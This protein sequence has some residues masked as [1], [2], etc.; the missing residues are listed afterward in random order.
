MDAQA[1]LDRIAVSQPIKPDFEALAQL[2]LAH[3]LTV[4]FE[5]LS[6]M[7]GEPILLDEARLLEKIVGRRRGGFCYELNGAFAWLLRQVGFD[8]TYISG[9]VYNT[10]TG[11]FGPEFDHMALIVQL[12][13]PYLV[14][15]GF[16]DSAR[17]PISLPDGQC[18]DVSGHYRLDLADPAGVLYHFQRQGGAGWETEYAFTLQPRQLT[19][20]T[21]MCEDQQYSPDSHFTQRSICTRATPTGRLTLSTDALT[22]TE[23]GE[24]R[25]IPLTPD[26]YSAIL[27]RE[28]GIV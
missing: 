16:G 2:Q 20:Y 23:A 17:Q 24:K 1:Y 26:E 12:D 8:V 6:V 11:K 21:P 15:V 18:V 4:P 7:R 10:S 19:E 9:R 27:Q 22:I 3:L 28:F 14:D 25:K 13:Q 5:N